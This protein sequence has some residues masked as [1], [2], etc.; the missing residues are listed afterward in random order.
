MVDEF[1]HGS[2]VGGFEY[3]VNSRIIY[4]DAFTDS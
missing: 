3:F 1:V 4:N 2:M